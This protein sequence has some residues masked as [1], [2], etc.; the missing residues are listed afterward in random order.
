MCFVASTNP[1]T[2]KEQIMST[3]TKRKP[4]KKQF[5]PYELLAKVASCCERD[6]VGRWQLFGDRAGEFRAVLDE[7]AGAFPE[8]FANS[9]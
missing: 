4:A 9:N 1:N 7:I 6:E 8:V 3:T 2:I 5:T